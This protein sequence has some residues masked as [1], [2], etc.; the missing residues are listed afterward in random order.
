[1]LKKALERQAHVEEE[2]RGIRSRMP[3]KDARKE[4]SPTA[5]DSAPQRYFGATYDLN[6]G[7]NGSSPMLYSYRQDRSPIQAAVFSADEK[8]QD[9]ESE[10]EDELLNV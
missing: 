8:D 10:P 5:V 6:S 9:Q 2:L 7:A 1:M 4:A 3:S